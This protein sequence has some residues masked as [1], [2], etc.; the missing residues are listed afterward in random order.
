MNYKRSVTSTWVGS[1]NRF[2]NSLVWVRVTGQ[3]AQQ[4]G[5]LVDVLPCTDFGNARLVF[6]CE[7]GVRI[8]VERHQTLCC[9]N[10]TYRVNCY[11]NAPL[12]RFKSWTGH[13]CAD[14]TDVWAFRSAVTIVRWANLHFQQQIKAWGRSQLHVA[15]A[16][17]L[18]YQP[19]LPV[20]VLIGF[21]VEV[22]S[23][24]HTPNPHNTCPHHHYTHT[25]LTSSPLISWVYANP[26][27]THRLFSGFPTMCSRCCHR[28]NISWGKNASCIRC[29][30]PHLPSLTHIC[31]FNPH[32]LLSTH[33]CPL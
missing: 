30:R 32:L 14:V 17:P 29:L 11:R 1:K 19:V 6:F 4:D 9:I 24:T 25:R 7:L 10:R 15:S 2:L 8:G 3:E 18:P 13:G 33:M 12:S 16:P 5:R 27:M 21:P 23:H 28:F 22:L 20:G 26:Y 31:P